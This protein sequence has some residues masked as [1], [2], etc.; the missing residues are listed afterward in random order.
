MM[1]CKV[2]GTIEIVRDGEREKVDGMNYVMSLGN[3]SDLISVV[4]YR[5]R[6]IIR[7]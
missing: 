7:L 4:A 3:A 2:D 5:G 6:I 1:R